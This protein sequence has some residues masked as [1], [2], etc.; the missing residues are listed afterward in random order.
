M[1][2]SSR[3]N[4][5]SGRRAARSGF[6][7]GAELLNPRWPPSSSTGDGPRNVARCGGAPA[8]VAGWRR[9]TTV[10]EQHPSSEPDGTRLDAADQHR[11][12]PPAAPS[13]A[14]LPATPVPGGTVGCTVSGRPASPAGTVDG[15]RAPPADTVPGRPARADPSRP[16]CPRPTRLWQTCPRPT[17]PQPDPPWQTSGR[18]TCPGRPVP[19]GPAERRRAP[20]SAA[21][22][23]ARRTG[24][25]SRAA[26]MSSTPWRRVPHR[27]IRTSR[28]TGRAGASGPGTAAGRVRAS[29]VTGDPASRAVGPGRRRRHGLRP[30]RRR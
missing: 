6:G 24:A 5:R 28:R 27:H 3:Q 23:A 12:E 21:P 20:S 15:S 7:P 11:P 1:V 18:P 22:G 2:G 9:E 10:S 30:Y 8:V 14:D 13:P 25:S 17:R 19:G 4:H 16:T 29:R 26:R